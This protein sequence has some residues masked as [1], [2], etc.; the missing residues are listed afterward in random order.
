MITILE[1]LKHPLFSNFTLASGRTG[2]YNAVTGTGIFEWESLAEVESTFA[3]GEFIVTTLSQAKESQS[4]ANECLKNLILR[5]ISCICIKSIYYTEIS[6]EIKSLS[7]EYHVPIFFFQD[8][9]MDDILFTVKTAILSDGLPLDFA[10]KAMLLMEDVVPLDQVKKIAKEINPYF[11]NNVRSI[12]IRITESSNSYNLTHLCNK[13]NFN[14]TSLNTE[15]FIYSLIPFK[16]SAILICTAKDRECLNSDSVIRQMDIPQ[17][18][19]ILG[20]SEVY[21]GLEN[22]SISIRESACA[23]ISA[24]LDSKKIALFKNIGLDQVIIPARTNTWT[25]S[26]YQD[27]RQKVM[28]YDAKHQISLMETLLIYTSANF[29]IQKTAGLL[30]QH[31]NTIRYRLDKAKTILELEDSAE[32]HRQLYVFSRLSKIYDLFD[33][34][35]D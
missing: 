30:F 16:E 17:E 32:F 10:E 20:V 31:H 4:L 35:C 23:Y 7:D 13:L 21:E 14:L 34:I 15:L 5:N 27:I 2:L 25:K 1:L 26:F 9:F 22:L 8:T 3:S 12:Y 33:K 11:L 18:H 6:P 28:D 19:I 29:D 24:S